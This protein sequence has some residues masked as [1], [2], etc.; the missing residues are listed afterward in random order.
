MAEDRGLGGHLGALASKV[1]YKIGFLRDSLTEYMDIRNV[2]DGLTEEKER[3]QQEKQRLQHERHANEEALTGTKDMLAAARDALAASTEEIYRMNNELEFLKRKLQES[4]AKN[5]QAEKQCGWATRLIQPRGVQTRSMQKQKR[6]SEGPLGYGSEEN[7][8]TTQLDGQSLFRLESM[9][10][11][12]VQKR[13][14]EKQKRRAE[15]YVGNEADKLG[16]LEKRPRQVLISKPPVGQTSGVLLSKDDDLEAVRDELIK[17]FLAID[18]GGLKL[19]IKEMGELNKKPFKD[20]CLAKL[21]PE[22]VGAAS[23]QLYTT[24]QQKLGDL[25]WNPFKTVTVDGNCQEIVNI[26]DNKLQELKRMWGEGAY[27][28]VVSALV[29][30]KEYNRLS[31]RSIAYEL[32]NYKE[33]R[34]A[35]TREGVEYMCNKV[36]QLTAAKRRKNNRGESS[37]TYEVVFA[38]SSEVV[39]PEE[40]GKSKISD[41]SL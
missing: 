12:N 29:E 24:W 22:E 6:P 13:S 35:T 1:N 18:T 31:D 26:D 25:S 20:A 15:G 19:G 23:S 28:A 36:K 11:L 14:A 37:G 16:L 9:E 34:K 3:L 4:E 33:G 41:L 39:A 32:W 8:Y 7:Q 21:P 27:N 2:I 5:N 10:N 17:G 40:S 38:D 30:M